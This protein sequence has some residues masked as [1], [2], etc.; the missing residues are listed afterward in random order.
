MLSTGSTANAELNKD[1]EMHCSRPG[2]EDVLMIHG[3]MQ[4]SW[5][6]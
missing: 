6:C 4:L 2:R 1:A 5:R 3:V